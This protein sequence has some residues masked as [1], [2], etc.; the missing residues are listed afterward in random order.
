MKNILIIIISIFFFQLGYGQDQRIYRDFASQQYN[1]QLSQRNSSFSKARKKMEE[2]IIGFRKKGELSAVTIPIVFHVLYS[3]NDQRISEA[4]LA[5]QIAALNRDFANE[6]QKDN[7]P[8]NTKE[9][10]LS[11]AANTDIQFCLATETP[12]RKVSSGINYLQVKN[13]VWSTGNEMKSKKEGGTEAWKTSDYLNI[14]VVNLE[15][16]LGGFSQWPNGPKDTD[17]IVVDYRF[18]GPNSRHP[19][20]YNE[21][22][23]LT[24]LVGSYLG[25]NE[26]WIERGR[27]QDDKVEDTPIHNSPNFRCP[28]YKHKTTCRGNDIE[29]TMNFM[30]YTDDACMYMFTEGQ[31]WRMQAVLAKGG[32]R[33]ELT[34][35]KV[36]CDPN[37][38]LLSQLP[39]N[40]ED[41]DNQKILSIPQIKIFPNP[42]KNDEAFLEISSPDQLNSHIRIYN[43]IGKLMNSFDWMLDAGQQTRRL[44]VNNWSSGIYLI[45]ITIGGEQYNQKLI[46]NNN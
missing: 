4:Q 46:L 23:T 35:G 16:S 33:Y 26:L 30:D 43:Q 7:H 24:H 39:L 32:P 28:G 29:M 9:R 27:C 45:Q 31:K 40:S 42:S 6:A 20:P 22:K 14:W 8:A 10:F 34:K 13:K 1:D 25:L 18:I 19:H 12:N 17:G 41:L 11:R 2:H 37:L 44:N 15:G 38:N 5:A 3:N 21:G 36:Q